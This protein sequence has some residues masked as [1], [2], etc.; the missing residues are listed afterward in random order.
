LEDQRTSS[1]DRPQPSRLEPSSA[2]RGSEARFVALRAFGDEHSE[3]EAQRFQ[4]VPLVCIGVTPATPTNTGRVGFG[5]S[6]K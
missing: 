3:R 5:G 1:N 2:K 4:A 6:E